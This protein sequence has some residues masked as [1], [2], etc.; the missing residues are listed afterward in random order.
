MRDGRH[1]R[2]GKAFE[3]PELVQAAV[4]LWLNEMRFE[5]HAQTAAVLGVDRF[6]RLALAEPEGPPGHDDAPQDD[7]AFAVAGRGVARGL[8]SVSRLGGPVRR[9]R[10]GARAP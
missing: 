9:V 7:P 3:E 6:R 1:R 2:R 4:N 10:R 5:S 8:V